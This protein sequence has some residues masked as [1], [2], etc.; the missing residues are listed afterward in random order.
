MLPPATSARSC[1]SSPGATTSLVASTTRIP[2][3]NACSTTT[4][5]A[6]AFSSTRYVSA[7]TRSRRSASRFARLVE[8]WTTSAS[9]CDTSRRAGSEDGDPALERPGRT[10][11]QLEILDDDVRDE[12]PI[13]VEVVV[14]RLTASDH[15]NPAV[16]VDGRDRGT[17]AVEDHDIGAALCC[18]RGAGCDVRDEDRAGQAAAR[19]PAADRRHTCERSDLEVIGGSMEPGAR[20]LRRAPRSTAAPRRPRARAGRRG[21]S[22]PRRHS[23]PARGAARDGWSRRSS[24]RA[25]PCRSRRSTAGRMPRRTAARNESRPRRR[26]VPGPAPSTPSAAVR[27]GR[28]RAR[29]KDRSRSPHPQSRRRAGR[30]SPH[31]PAASRC[32]PRGSRRP[33][34]TG[35]PAGRRAPQAHSAPRR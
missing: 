12:P 10:E 5:I 18:E 23:G 33:I 22:Q 15:E 14:A 16:D 3:A 34:R 6:A 24:P 20:P 11:P 2:W 7:S 9:R 13:R 28:A 17:A 32:L 25:F 19:A 26:A 31:R 30:R 27:P 21:P 29:R 4:S 35:V 1:S 8:T